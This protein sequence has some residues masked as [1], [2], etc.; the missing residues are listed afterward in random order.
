MLKVTKI[1][2]NQYQYLC[3]CGREIIFETDEK[4]IIETYKCLDCKNKIKEKAN[5]KKRAN[6]TKK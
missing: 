2:H 4:N 6:K 3:E 5:D 1:G